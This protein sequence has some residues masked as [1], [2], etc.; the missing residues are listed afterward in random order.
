MWGSRSEYKESQKETEK[1]NW[2]EIRE[3]EMKTLNGGA[4]GVGASKARRESWLPKEWRGY[5]NWLKI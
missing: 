1:L 5:E 2:Q 4:V 3:M